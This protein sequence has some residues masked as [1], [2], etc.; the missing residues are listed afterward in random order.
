MP[1]HCTS[2]SISAYEAMLAGTTHSLAPKRALSRY[3]LR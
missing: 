2:A 3:R 1:T